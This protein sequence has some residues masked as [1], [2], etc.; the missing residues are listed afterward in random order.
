MGAAIR[1]FQVPESEAKTINPY[2]SEPPPTFAGITAEFSGGDYEPT[3]YNQPGAQWKG[4]VG[5]SDDLETESDS[6]P[7]AALSMVASLAAQLFA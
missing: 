5:N 3:D 4:L 6:S 1:I 7:N 2:R